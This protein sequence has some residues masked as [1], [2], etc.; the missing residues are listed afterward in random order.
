MTY[1]N[2]LNNFYNKF[3]EKESY[4]IIARICTLLAYNTAID[5]LGFFKMQQQY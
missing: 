1:Y 3:I 5:S 2:I 4:K